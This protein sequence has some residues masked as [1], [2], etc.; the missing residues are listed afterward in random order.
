MEVDYWKEMFF[1]WF[2]SVKRYFAESVR[3][4]FKSKAEADFALIRE[5]AD[6][7]S[8][9]PWEQLRTRYERP[10]RFPTREAFDLACDRA[11]AKYPV[12]LGIALDKY[13]AACVQRLL[14]TDDVERPLVVKVKEEA[15][16]DRPGTVAPRF[17]TFDDGVYSIVVTS[18]GGLQRPANSGLGLQKAVQQRLRKTAPSTLD[19]LEFDSESSMFVVR[20]HSLDSLA[21][22]SQAIFTTAAAAKE[23]SSS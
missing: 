2:E 1:K 17:I 7:R 15:A 14:D 8:D 6:I 4:E 12:N 3:E 19:Q 18:F 21:A 5:K 23:T 20:S 16:A 11:K 10:V 22:V 9:T 13:L